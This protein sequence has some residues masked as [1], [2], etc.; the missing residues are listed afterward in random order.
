[1]D[2]AT[3]V[4]LM[5][6]TNSHSL[7]AEVSIQNRTT[8][9]AHSLSPFVMYLRV[10]A[11]VKNEW[12]KLLLTDARRVAELN[13]GDTQMRR[14]RGAL[15]SHIE[16][17]FA[18]IAGRLSLCPADHVSRRDV[19]FPVS[20]H[21]ICFGSSSAFAM[22]SPSRM[23]GTPVRACVMSPVLSHLAKRHSR[24]RASAIRCLGRA[25]QSQVAIHHDGL[26][27]PVRLDHCHA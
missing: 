15:H 1:M 22:F 24:L 2:G 16:P 10:R 27:S 21:R 17:V 9:N 4:Q 6:K 11:A 23:S 25:G 19:A 20:I 18:R 26:S 7:Q 8:P 14:V 13:A 12:K 5:E 3:C